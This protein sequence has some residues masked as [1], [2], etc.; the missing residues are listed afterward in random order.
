[1]KKENR[2][3]FGKSSTPGHQVATA[4]GGTCADILLFLRVVN[5][6]KRTKKPSEWKRLDLKSLSLI[7][8]IKK[9]KGEGKEKQDS[10]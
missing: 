1:M 5:F 8:I 7:N 6:L 2:F 9:K 3:Q 4:D 10:L